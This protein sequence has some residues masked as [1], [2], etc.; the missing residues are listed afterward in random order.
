MTMEQFL[1]AY[2][3]AATFSSFQFL[4]HHELVGTFSGLSALYKVHIPKFK[5]PFIRI[6]GVSVTRCI[7]QTRQYIIQ[8][9]HDNIRIARQGD[10]TSAL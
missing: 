3:I 6:W 10:H 4:F 7:P 9:T 8:L 5:K 2:F 1:V